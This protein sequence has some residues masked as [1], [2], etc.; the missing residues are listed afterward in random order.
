M[1]KDMRNTIGLLVLLLGL[2]L[3]VGMC[4]CVK[5]ETVNESPQ[6]EQVATKSE[7]PRTTIQT[8]P[9]LVHHLP[10]P[11]I[12]EQYNDHP[13]IVCFNLDCRRVSFCVVQYCE[14]E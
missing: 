4:S 12:Q 3:T 11:T 8:T 1:K 6:T 5:A 7:P 10:F 14:W 13:D 2:I 9:Y